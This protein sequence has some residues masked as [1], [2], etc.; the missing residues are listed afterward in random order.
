MTELKVFGKDRADEA[1]ETLLERAQ[2][3]AA[4][5]GGR[6]TVNEYELDSDEAR[7]LGV[8]RA[9][10]L[11]IGGDLAYVGTVPT[12]GQLATMVGVV[13]GQSQ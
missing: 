11:A 4:S 2:R 10:A 12:V 8:A 3:I 7:R 1:Y 5:F 13:L 9:P 6:V